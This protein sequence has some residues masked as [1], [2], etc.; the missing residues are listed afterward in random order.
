MRALLL[1]LL[2]AAGAAAAQPAPRSA[3]IGGE[4]VI[5]VLDK[6]LGTSAEFRLKPGEGF[7][8]GRL[9]GTLRGC[10]RTQPWEAQPEEGAFVQLVETTPTGN[11]QDRSRVRTIFSGWLFARSPS[12]NPLSH[13][14][15]DVWLKACA[16]AGPDGPKSPAPGRTRSIGNGPGTAGR[17]TAGGA[18]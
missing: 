16:M 13:P 15:Y 8:F 11:R 9:S 17:T 12:L 14:V 2:A 18:G 4:A 1:A 6:R 10:E 5:G 7:R 3:P